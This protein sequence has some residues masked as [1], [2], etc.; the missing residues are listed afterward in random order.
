MVAQLVHKGAVQ[1]AG[2]HSLHERA[3][4]AVDDVE[5]AGAPRHHIMS[6]GQLLQSVLGIASF[7][8]LAA[9]GMVV[10]VV[11]RVER[12]AVLRP[13]APVCVSRLL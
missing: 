13:S 4:L 5:A 2:N 6:P 1:V 8:L 12:Q 7:Q 10:L 11:D 3:G 9:G